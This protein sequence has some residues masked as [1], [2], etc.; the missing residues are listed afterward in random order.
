M[1]SQSI[2][3]KLYALKWIKSSTGLPL[4]SPY[5]GMNRIH[6]G[7]YKSSFQPHYFQDY[8]TYSRRGWNSNNCHRH[9][10]SDR[11]C[12]WGQTTRNRESNSDFRRNWFRWTGKYSYFRDCLWAYWKDWIKISGSDGWLMMGIEERGCYCRFTRFELIHVYG[13]PQ[14]P[15]CIIKFK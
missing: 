6:S 8:N 2:P 1:T 9:W 5:L 10:S 12:R 15:F 3:L 14:P 7:E 4:I 11:S 13:W